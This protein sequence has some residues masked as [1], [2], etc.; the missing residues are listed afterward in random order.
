MINYKE[1]KAQIVEIGNNEARFLLNLNT[2][3]RKKKNKK[4]AEYVSVI[5]DGKFRFNGA[6]IVVSEDGILL[7]GQHRLMAVE[8]LAGYTIKTV[9]VTGVKKDT[10]ETIDIGSKRTNAD[11]FS[12]DGVKNSTALASMTRLVMEEFKLNIRYERGWS[13]DKGKEVRD[14]IGISYTPEEILSY[15]NERKDMFLDAIAFSE[16]LYAN[17]TKIK[18]LTAATI[19]AYFILLQREDYQMAKNFLRELVNGLGHNQNSNAA[20]ILRNK[21]LDITIK[22]Q[23]VSIQEHRDLLVYSFRKY[24]DGIDIKR[25]KRE[26]QSFAKEDK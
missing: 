19:G 23:S 13:S 24:K 20:I 2:N 7:D 17:N 10:M 1:E 12:I 8:E 18:G 11:F 16:H 6:S 5:K 14:R 9:L 15:F 22:K 3:N 21:L 25:L 4:V 26:P